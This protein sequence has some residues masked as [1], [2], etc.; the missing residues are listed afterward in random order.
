MQLPTAQ[1]VVNRPWFCVFSGTADRCHLLGQRVVSGTAPSRCSETNA[2]HTHVLLKL[3]AA[4]SP[5]NINSM[6]YLLQAH[7]GK[8]GPTTTRLHFQKIVYQHWA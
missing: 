6:W 5:K 8:V 1:L 2:N 3:R 7:H 4:T